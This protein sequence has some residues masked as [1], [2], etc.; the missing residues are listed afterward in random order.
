[1]VIESGDSSSVR[2]DVSA[3]GRG[4]AVLLG[5]EDAAVVAGDGPGPAAASPPRRGWLRAHRTPIVL[6]ALLALLAG[7]TMLFALRLNA[8]VASIARV[9]TSLPEG[10]RPVAGPVGPAVDSVSGPPVTLLLAGVDNGD[11]GIGIAEAVR[12]GRWQPG[13]F[14]SDTLMVL[15]IAA[16]RRAAYLVSIPRDTLVTIPGHGQTKINAAFSY[17]GPALMQLTVEQFTGQRMDHL[18]LVDWNGLRDLSL[19]FGGVAVDVAEDVR[20]PISGRTWT[21]GV[22]NL[23]GSDVLAYVRMRYGLPGGDLDRIQRQQN[24]MR[25]MLR[26]LGSTGT[27]ANPLTLDEAV[28]AITT[29]VVVDSGFDDAQIR[30]LAVQSRGLRP[31][32]VRYVTTPVAGASTTPDGASVLLPQTDQT[33]DLFAAMARDDLGGYL[34]THPELTQLRPVDQVR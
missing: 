27:L 15:H 13:R 12:S 21:K 29:N 2:V 23:Q 18:V 4:D 22:H 10:L 30:D 28:Q 34:Q 24:V 16:D 31:G 20:D 25:E 1:M 14:R 9:D 8:M 17:G 19:A 33:R 7:G 32:D 5:G 26:K 3:A 11:D 6:L